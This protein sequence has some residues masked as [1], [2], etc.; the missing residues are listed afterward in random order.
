MCYSPIEIK[1]P[2]TGKYMLVNCRKCLECRQARAREWSIRCALES[3]KYVDNCFIT[4]TYAP[5]HNPITLQ[6][7]DVQKFIKRLRKHI[8]ADIKI[9]YFACG[10]Y[11]TKRHRP[12]YHIIIFNYNFSDRYQTSTSARGYKIYRSAEL[13]QL[14]KLGYS[15]VQT[16]S[17][18][19]IA[20]CSLYASPP[21][22]KLPMHLQG[23]PEFNLMS[24]S[25]GLDTILKNMDKYIDTDTIWYDCKAY[26]IPNIALDKYFGKHY[27]DE[28]IDLRPQKLKNIK[29]NRMEK[30]NIQYTAMSRKL[31]DSEYIDDKAVLSRK[32]ELA[33]NKRK[34]LP[35][36]F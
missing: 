7:T 34:K 33:E 13:E 10:E 20:Y 36:N 17:I 24:Q 28:Q 30:G 27:V 5:E 23:A 22:K 26:N 21:P 2:N 8:G 31:S 11:G 35:D 25:M 15:T 18:N 16:V 9:K 29:K 19:S 4:L 12:H 1:N 3:D 14:W 32:K 6:K